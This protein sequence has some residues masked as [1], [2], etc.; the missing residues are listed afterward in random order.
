VLPEHLDDLGRLKDAA[1]PIA[2]LS[3]LL[4]R[5]VGSAPASRSSLTIS[6]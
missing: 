3:C 4:S 5:M 1:Q 6:A 2:S